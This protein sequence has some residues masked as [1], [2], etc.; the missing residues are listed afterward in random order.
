M[1]VEYINSDPNILRDYEL[2]LKLSDTQCKV[3]IAM[4]HFLNYVVDKTHPIA[5]I[6]G[7]SDAPP[8][9]AFLVS[10]T[11]LHCWHSW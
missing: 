3:D 1:A 10:L 11:P 5:G 8:L 9:L 6:L 7:K 4:K 2:E